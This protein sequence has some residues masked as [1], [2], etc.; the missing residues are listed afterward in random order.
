MGKEEKTKHLPVSLRAVSK[1]LSGTTADSQGSLSLRLMIDESIDPLLLRAVRE[2]F[3]PQ[4]TNIEIELVSYFDRLPT[5]G[6]GLVVAGAYAR[7]RPKPVDASLTVIF[8]AHSELSYRLFRL[9]SRQVP[10][11]VVSLH[12]DVFMS[13]VDPD[14]P[15]YSEALEQLVSVIVEPVHGID[16]FYRGFFDRRIG[17]GVVT[18]GVG[19]DKGFDDLFQ[20][21]ANRILREFPDSSLAWAL[22][23]DFV[24]PAKVT[25]IIHANSIQNGVISL[26]FFLPGADLP[27]LTLN[28]MRMFLQIAA[29][30]GLKLSFQRYRELAAIL[31]AAF[32]FRGLARYLV[33]RLPMLGWALKPAISLG[34]TFALGRA[35]DIYIQRLV[36]ADEKSDRVSTPALELGLELEL[37][38]L[39]LNPADLELFD[40]PDDWDGDINE[41]LGV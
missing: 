8:A 11:L 41:A 16:R 15:E 39:G 35:A 14:S 37:A 28:Q 9:S 30:Y 6:E 31:L 21:L 19:A 4:N 12:P 22:S 27:I 13:Q 26:A 25:D 2:R 7:K 1:L 5:A 17:R 24:R 20:S 36:A 40:S 18:A 34:T 29:A 10:T 38:K 3:R 23:L 33:A 32:G